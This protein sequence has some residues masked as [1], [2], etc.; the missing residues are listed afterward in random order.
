M[1]GSC[2]TCCGKSDINEIQTSKDLADR[3]EIKKNNKTQKAFSANPTH[4]VGT[5][6]G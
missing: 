2:S 6:K 4:G 5:S 1:G 3:G